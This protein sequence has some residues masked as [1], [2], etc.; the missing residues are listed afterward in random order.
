MNRYSKG[1]DVPQDHAEAVKWFSMAAEQGNQKAKVSLGYMYKNGQ[2]VPQDY[3]Q[4]HKWYNLANVGRLIGEDREIYIKDRDRVAKKMTS[5]Q[6]A[7][8]QRLATEWEP[9]T[10]E[11]IRKELKIGPP[12]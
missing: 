11:V 5:E 12:E 10:W 7:E 1:E 4:A 6:V 8:A 9:K 3:V 2:G